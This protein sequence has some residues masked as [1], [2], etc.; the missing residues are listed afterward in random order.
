M[1]ATRDLR[2]KLHKMTTSN[3]MLLFENHWIIGMLFLVMVFMLIF[4][5][6][7]SKMF[8]NLRS[9][10]AFGIAVTLVFFSLVYFDILYLLDKDK[11]YLIA[12]I[13]LVCMFIFFI[14]YKGFAF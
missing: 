7:K 2:A 13:V 14:L 6:K 8:G 10:W 9:V 4:T 3:T 12:A 11:Q 1:T 5:D